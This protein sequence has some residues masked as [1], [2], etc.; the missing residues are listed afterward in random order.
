[1]F[2]EI[3][4]TLLFLI[5]PP[6]ELEEESI[7]PNNFKCVYFMFNAYQWRKLSAPSYICNWA[8]LF[9]LRIYSIV[10]DWV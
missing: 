2:K 10:A 3:S 1:M 8:F 9:L 6:T 5:F 4:Y 7:N